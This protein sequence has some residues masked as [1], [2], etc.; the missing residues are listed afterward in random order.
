MGDSGFEEG[1]RAGRFFAGHDH[2]EGDARG[3]VDAHMH[4]LPSDAPAVALAFAAAGDA[5]ANTF[6]S[7]EFLDIDMDK[8]AGMLA[9]IA[10]DGLGRIEVLYPVQ[11]RA[12]QNPADGCRRRAVILPTCFPVRR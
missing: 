8:F 7:S 4:E 5:M 12:L 6:K 9:L 2:G 3:V 10:P 11:P 1:D